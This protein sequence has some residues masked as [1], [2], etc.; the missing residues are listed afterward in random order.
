[1]HVTRQNEACRH[2][3]GHEMISLF[4]VI[5][6][7]TM[8]FNLVQGCIYWRGMFSLLKDLKANTV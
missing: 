3:G 2:V 4:A 8:I 6:M 5:M 7:R 1:M